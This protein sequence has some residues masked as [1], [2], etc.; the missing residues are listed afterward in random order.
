[1]VIFICYVNYKI[2]TNPSFQ[3]TQIRNLKW[4]WKKEHIY[5][6]LYFGLQT[7]C[8]I[9]SWENRS[10]NKEWRLVAKSICYNRLSVH[11]IPTLCP[12]FFL[13]CCFWPQETGYRGKVCWM[14]H[15]GWHSLCVALY[16]EAGRKKAGRSYK[17]AVFVLLVAFQGEVII[18]FYFIIFIG[19]NSGLLLLFCLLHSEGLGGDLLEPNPVGSVMLSWYLWSQIVDAMWGN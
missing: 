17:R 6:N 4:Y 10:L 5:T 1:M 12:L 18:F 11:V 9:V 14:T 16:K 3:N 13:S 7:D 15:E 2:A 19:F 8:L